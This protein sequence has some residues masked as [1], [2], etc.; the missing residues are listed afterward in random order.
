[1][2]VM[3]AA[4]VVVGLQ[5]HLDVQYTL[6]FNVLGVLIGVGSSSSSSDKIKVTLSQ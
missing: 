2:N 1:M 3:L 6:Y 5:W 4:T